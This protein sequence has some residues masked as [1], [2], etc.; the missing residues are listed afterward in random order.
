MNFFDFLPRHIGEPPIQVWKDKDE[1]RA[2]IHFGLCKT[3]NLHNQHIRDGQEI[4]RVQRFQNE[5][6][7]WCHGSVLGVDGQ[8]IDEGQLVVPQMLDC[9]GEN[10]ILKAL[11]NEGRLRKCGRF[12]SIGRI[13]YDPWLYDA[14]DER[15]LFEHPELA[16][17]GEISPVL[18]HFRMQE[19]HEKFPLTDGMELYRVTAKRGFSP[20]NSFGFGLLPFAFL[21]PVDFVARNPAERP[22]CL[23]DLLRE[24]ILVR[25]GTCRFDPVEGFWKLDPKGKSKG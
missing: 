19:L 8:L 11:V 25:A 18:D 10:G 9:E 16:E 23:A 1:R 24:K 14:A 21:V 13:E 6:G 20:G 2:T 22:E 12:H 4:Y 7:A 3:V 5:A 15:L 17:P